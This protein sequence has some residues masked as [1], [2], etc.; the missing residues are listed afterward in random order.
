MPV[1]RFRRD[2]AGVLAEFSPQG[3]RELRLHRI[4]EV[5]VLS[6]GSVDDRHSKIL[7]T[8]EASP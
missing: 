2:A 8:P 4:G 7:Q 3:L 5:L 1:D 6:P